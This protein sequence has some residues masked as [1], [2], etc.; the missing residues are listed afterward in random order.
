MKLTV[1]SLYPI[2]PP[3]SGFK[4]R[5]FYLYKELA[6]YMSVEIISMTGT[7]CEP[8]NDFIAP[9]LKEIRIPKSRAQLSLEQS[10]AKKYGLQRTDV[11]DFSQI[12]HFDAT[13][14]FVQ[15]FL[16]SSKDADYMVS[17]QA[18]FYPMIKKYSNK[19]I[20]H[21]SHNVEYMLKK[22]L[23]DK[24]GNGTKELL[25]LIFSTEEQMY[26]NAYLNFVCTATDDDVQ[27]YQELYGK[28]E[29]DVF[30]MPN[31]VDTKEIKYISKQER[32]SN[33][34]KYDIKNRTALFMGSAHP[35]NLEA[36]DEIIRLAAK[37]KDVDF[38]IMGTACN[39]YKQGDL[40]YNVKLLGVVHNEEKQKVLSYVDIALNPI[41]KGAGTNVKMV[42]YMSAGIPVITTPIGTRGLGLSSDTVDICEITEFSQCISSIDFSKTKNA[43]DYVESTFD[44]QAIACNYKELLHCSK[45]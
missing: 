17:S 32:I 6:K 22:Q 36:C 8:F 1:L 31:G 24:K 39:S 19:P 3:N 18:Y 23:L 10:M 7:E 5:V 20:I 27:S 13:Q 21:D 45:V 12:L 14:E 16:D 44:W 35:P 34:Q 11:F 28:I 37:V 40:P 26:K 33:K 2:Y 29:K 30:C 43:R 15:A 9:N 38:L 41:L 25:D 4:N 42:E